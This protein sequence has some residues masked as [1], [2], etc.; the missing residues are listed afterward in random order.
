MD[1]M[2][3]E[4]KILLVFII[5]MAMVLNA[6]IMPGFAEENSQDSLYDKVIARLHA[7]KII[8]IDLSTYNPNEFITRAEFT[9]MIIKMLGMGD[10]D[11][12]DSVFEDVEQHWARKYINAAHQ[13]S[14]V[15][16]VSRNRFNPE[17]DIT[18]EQA[19]TMLIKAMGFDVIAKESG[20]Y[21]VGYLTVAR[22][23]G[24]IKNVH[25]QA[26]INL[27]KGDAA[28]LIDNSLEVP[29]LI[30]IGTSENTRYVLSG[31]KNT[32]KETIL[33]KYLRYDVYKGIIIEI[34]ADKHKLRINIDNEIR[35]YY[36]DKKFD[37]TEIAETYVTLYV[38]RYSELVKYIEVEDKI[39]VY[40][41]FISLVNGDDNIEN[42]YFTSQLDHVYLK[43]QD[44]QFRVSKELVV[45]FNNELIVNSP[46]ALIG[47]FGK[48]FVQDN[49]IIKIEA[50]QLREGGII[51]RADPNVLKYTHGEVNENV[52]E[53]FYNVKDLLIYI[54]GKP[55][56][57][58][59]DLKSDMV[60]DYWV[61]AD[62][63]KFVIVASSRV[64]KGRLESY[65]EDSICLNGEF[66][67][68]DSKYGFYNYSIPKSRY[69]KNEPLSDIIGKQV[70]IYVDDNKCVR[71]IK[72]DENLIR[73]QVFC[74]VVMAADKKGFDKARLKIY[75]LSNGQGEKI[76]YVSDKM[77]DSP[78]SYE[79][80]A[81]V[82]ANVEGKGF[83]KFTLNSAGEII[84]IE[85]VDFWGHSFTR[86]SA[87][88]E[89]A[90]FYWIE[91]LYIKD[92][93][94]FG[95]YM[96][97]GEFK[98]KTFDWNSFLRNSRVTKELVITTD[99]HP[100]YNPK[101]NY[102][103]FTGG[104]DTICRNDRFVYILNSITYLDDDQ[105]KLN[106][107]YRLGP[108][109]YTVSKK[110][111]EEN[112]LKR[113][114]LLVFNDGYISGD[115]IRI[116]EKYDLSGPIEN[117]DTDVFKPDTL[118]GFYRADKVL[119]RDDDVVQFEVDG[120]VTDVMPVY[121]YGAIYEKQGDEFKVATGSSPIANISSGDNV[122]FYVQKV[123]EARAVSVIIYEKTGMVP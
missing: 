26:G 49:E 114:M 45:Y 122:W 91:N 13:M 4:K 60:F 18:Y 94:L 121:M 112:N 90:N 51:Y 21:P 99:Y 7:L 50:Y 87:F 16:G 3:R 80:A 63:K 104:I 74:G 17:G 70:T 123:R 67:E 2:R 79:Y 73:D 84:K 66:Y 93:I 25:Y 32:D 34:D 117:W 55:Y 52:I 92:A 62:E 27:T 119:L 14:I 65:S 53:G 72:I 37:L 12:G 6:N 54:D 9:S 29:L 58:M 64:L 86:S 77:K 20:G 120:M 59:R 113:K 83:F 98:V 43:N 81:S 30:Q 28:V 111:V 100:I 44:Q 85:N 31:T 23:Q 68:I 48:I 116:I 38:D 61:S 10:V 24:I 75:K 15:E 42:E 101:P 39:K 118:T 36:V 71:Y 95:V 76:Y 78:I 105:C 89:N 106:M 46:I 33:S 5:I 96:D 109:T 97:D 8:D 57:E 69:I 115:P 56:S 19:V 103:M 47:A 82:A 88:K 22:Q 108:V 35:E 41:D 1:F 11:T 107:L 40:Y 110:F 102:V